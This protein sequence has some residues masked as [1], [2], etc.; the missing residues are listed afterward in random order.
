MV[1][2]AY[3]VVGNC[4][5]SRRML[6]PAVVLKR[7]GGRVKWDRPSTAPKVTDAFVEPSCLLTAKPGAGEVG[8]RAE[9]PR[10]CEGVHKGHWLAI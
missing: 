10:R 1:A 5:S 2:Q 6:Q 7:D 3:L 4:T 9:L 8:N